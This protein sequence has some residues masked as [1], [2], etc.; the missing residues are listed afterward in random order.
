MANS[1]SSSAPGSPGPPSR[2]RRIWDAARSCW[3]E[4]QTVCRDTLGR[5]ARKCGTEPMAQ[6]VFDFGPRKAA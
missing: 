3:I 6:L 1:R 5:Y 4:A 2:P